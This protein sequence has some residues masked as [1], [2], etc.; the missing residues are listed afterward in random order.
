MVDF[1]PMSAES[2]GV[3]AR[4]YPAQ[5]ST[6]LAPGVYFDDSLRIFRLRCKNAMYAFRVD[7][8]K[9]LEHLYWGPALP[10][11]DDI[12]YLA[13]S[14]VPAPF[15]P[16]G[17]VSVAKV[18]GLS[19]LE[20]IGDV[21]ELS[22]R[23]K[24]FTKQKDGE[25]WEGKQKGRRLENA[26]WRL[27]SMERSRGG[28]LNRDLSE[29]T[30]EG[31]L[32]IPQERPDGPTPP[33]E[34][35]APSIPH[36]DSS[37]ANSF[38]APGTSPPP[39]SFLPLGMAMSKSVGNVV[40]LER[41]AKA[42]RAAAEAA[43]FQDGEMGVAAKQQIMRANSAITTS[44]RLR[45]ARASSAAL[46]SLGTHG[47]AG[48]LQAVHHQ[49]LNWRHLDPETVGK[50]TKLMEYSDIGTGDY[51]EPSFRLRYDHDGSTVCPLEYKSHRI[52][53]GKPPMPGTLPGVYTDSRDEATTLIVEMHDPLYHSVFNLYYTVMHDYDVILRR[54]VVRNDGKNPV[55][56]QYVAAAT[57]DFD[58]EHR[59]YMTQLSGSWA[60]ER[61][62]VTRKLEDGATVVKS[63]RGASSHQFNPF[64][65][66]TP[67]REPSEDDGEC[68]G[69]CFVYSG[70]FSIVAEVS[71]NRRLRVNIGI[72]PEGFSWFLS[73][74]EDGNTFSSPEVL[75]SYS[76]SGLGEMSK[77]MHR[78][79]R[80]RLIPRSFRYKVPP[81]LLNTWEAVYF[82][83]KHEVI[84]QIADAAKKADIELLVLDDGWFSNRHDTSSGLGDWTV[85][86]NK[87]P[88]GID[89]LA[90]AVNEIGLKFGLWVEP[91]MVSANSQLFKDHEDWCLCVPDRSRT[92]GRNQL[93]LDFSRI[94]VVEYIFELLCNLLM[95]ANIEYVK[96]DMNRHLTEIF[97]QKW[98]AERQGEIAH[99]FILGVYDVLGRLTKAFPKVL[100]ETCS[101]GGGRFDCGM[102]YFSP[103]IWTSD[104]TDALS[105][106]KIQYGT[107]LA[108]P[109]C[110]MGSHVSSVPNHQTLRTSS[111]KTR[112]LVAMAGTYGYELDPRKWNLSEIAEIQ[113][114][115]QL[116]KRIAPLVYEGD[117]YRLWSP[118]EGDSCAWMF[119]SRDQ[120]RAV[121]MAINVRREVGH[122]EPRL[123]L[124]GLLQDSLYCVEERCPGTVVRNVD[125]G[126]ITHDP[127]GVYQF[128]RPMTITGRTLCK[129]GLPVK[130]LF[131]ADSV[132][133]ELN[134]VDDPS[135]CDCGKG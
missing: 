61:Q 56:L 60:R 2:H 4:S 62:V 112:S 3:R 128:G 31:A 16:V 108:Y 96:W 131:D 21:Q 73:T 99:R 25:E 14:H 135:I 32:Q 22:E 19:E 8:A 111:M 69:F 104:N 7:D 64:V 24:V 98:H 125:N 6:E 68:F 106:V 132:L 115:I 127:R 47:S 117:M 124:R 134:A 70:N 103:Q 94:E 87:L 63:T 123:R 89:G 30:I 55:C 76:D 67:N 84:V 83:V 1:V 75:M 59:Y 53:K 92:K 36:A 12:L 33:T 40:E 71:E 28:D 58:A 10:I 5:A 107:S 50:N 114:Y 78:L 18:L 88:F 72:N 48:D 41:L 29:A 9:N 121:V 86:K 20:E 110:A 85:D 120:R 82:D 102:M 37:V 80:E 74:H 52:L 79:M 27:W 66:I 43:M 34:K 126:A 81:I 49:E 130:F 45:P 42:Q 54:T 91:E 46:S 105:R 23:W 118:F 129:A 119:V 95:S 109:A 39:P 13:K 17:A 35:E 97:S 113:G 26:S 122:L 77:G 101:G 57:V 100:F 51:R 133:F 44:P 116:Q 65:V 93:V 90:R 38:G 15:D 11:A